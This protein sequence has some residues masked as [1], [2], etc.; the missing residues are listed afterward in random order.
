MAE[1]TLTDGAVTSVVDMSDDVLLTTVDNPWN[2]FTHWD[3]WYEFDE[4]KGYHTCSLL[5]RLSITSDELSD[6]DYHLAVY[7]GMLDVLDINP[8]G[9]HRIFKKSDPWPVKQG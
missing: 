4:S 7:Q 9:M 1:E 3:E 6:G 8:F 5:A 2:P